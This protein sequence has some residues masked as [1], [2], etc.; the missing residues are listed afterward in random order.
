MTEQHYIFTDSEFEI[1]FAQGTLVPEL[2][3]HEAHLR[4]AWI[5]VIHYG[6]EQ[7]IRNI[8]LQ[9]LRFVEHLGASDKYNYNLT[10]AAITIIA[11]F[12]ERSNAHHFADF[13]AEFPQ[14]KSNF[15]ELVA[16]HYSAI[17]H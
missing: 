7:A 5:H 11:H 6:R 8:D 15:R 3:T 2:F 12:M 16:V 9:L 4:L 10:V 17:N 13:I 14:L 1:H